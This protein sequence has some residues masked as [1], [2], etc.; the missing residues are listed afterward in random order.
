MSMQ[1]T[2]QLNFSLNEFKELVKDTLKELLANQTESF[3]QDEKLSQQQ[4]CTFLGISQTTIIDWKKKG[5]V[6]FHQL[7]GTRT[8]YYF[9]SELLKASQMMKGGANV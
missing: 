3:K 4:A 1:K 5:L 6:P 8:I 7:P 9:K 2:V